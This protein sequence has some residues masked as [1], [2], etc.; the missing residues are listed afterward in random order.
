VAPWPGKTAK[1]ANH[2]LPAIAKMHNREATLRVLFPFPLEMRATIGLKNIAQLP[3]SNCF[4]YDN[5]I[6]P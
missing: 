1:N 5:L 4:H 3:Y 2:A 6:L